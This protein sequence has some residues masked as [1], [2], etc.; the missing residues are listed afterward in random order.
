MVRDSDSERAKF[1]QAIGGVS[2]TDVRGYD[3][4][5]DTAAIGFEATVDLIVRA[6]SARVEGNEA[7]V[8]SA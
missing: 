7:G 5:V 3:L 1:I 8:P 6:V 4:A 2:W